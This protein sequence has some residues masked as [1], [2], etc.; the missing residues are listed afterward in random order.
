LPQEEI[1]P[2]LSEL[3]SALELVKDPETSSG[4]LA[5]GRE[6]EADDINFPDHE[7]TIV[8]KGVLKLIPK[9][10]KVGLPTYT[11][12]MVEKN[13]EALRKS[14]KIDQISPTRFHD[15]TEK[16]ARNPTFD[17]CLVKDREAT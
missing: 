6:R 11:F 12:R 8:N 5:K 15:I 9:E 16:F 7:I 2:K 1:K 4:A 14:F 3:E 13:N 17:Y 10:G